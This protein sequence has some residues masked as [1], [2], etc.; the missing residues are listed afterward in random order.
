MRSNKLLFLLLL[1]S[2]QAMAQQEKKYNSSHK[3]LGIKLMADIPSFTDYEEYAYTG[4]FNIH[5][6]YLYWKGAS[7]GFYLSSVYSP[8]FMDTEKVKY[9][10]ITN[11]INPMLYYGYDFRFFKKRLVQSIGALGGYH[12]FMHYSK[13]N[14]PHNEINRKYTTAF[15]FL[16]A[17]FLSQTHFFVTPN[18]AIGINYRLHYMPLT[19]YYNQNIELGIRYNFKSVSK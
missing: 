3:S 15:G 6:Q 18:W 7:V 9:R 10:Y 16:N 14:D 11:A 17:A 12:L 13:V 4:G 8:G 19:Y 1:L 5:Y 2:F